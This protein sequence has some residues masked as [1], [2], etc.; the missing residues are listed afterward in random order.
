METIIADETRGRRVRI[1]RITRS[2][3]NAPRRDPGARVGRLVQIYS[4]DTPD[5]G[6]EAIGSCDLAA[7]AEYSI[8]RGDRVLPLRT[9][10]RN[11]RRVI[12]ADAGDGKADPADGV[13]AGV[14]IVAEGTCDPA[15][16]P[17]ML[18]RIQGELDQVN[19]WLNGEIYEAR[20]E[21]RTADGAGGD[22]AWTSADIGAGPFYGGE[23]AASGLY[24]AMGL[25]AAT[26]AREKAGWRE[27]AEEAEAA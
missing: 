21:S 10:P 2:A 17:H 12:L 24:R 26:D 16:E 18:R 20:L 19:A 5:Y 13:L 11:A 7:T 1:R 27:T 3:R 6:D 4:L 22:P 9:D 25:P 8:A 23:H 15:G 14:Y